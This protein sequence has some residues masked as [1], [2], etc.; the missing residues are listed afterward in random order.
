MNNGPLI[1]LINADSEGSA[2][3]AHPDKRHP[4]LP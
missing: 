1:A 3:Y 4:H 2:D